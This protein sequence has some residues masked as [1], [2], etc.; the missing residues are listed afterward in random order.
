M[1]TRI[2]HKERA[3]RT[4]ETGLT[5]VTPLGPKNGAHWNQRL[6]KQTESVL[7][8][9]VLLLCF[10]QE[11]FK[12][13]GETKEFHFTTSPCK[14]VSKFQWPGFIHFCLFRFDW[15]Y[16][17]SQPFHLKPILSHRLSSPSSWAHGFCMISIWSHQLVSRFLDRLENLRILWI[18]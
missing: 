18:S 14:K 5:L 6:Q 1:V 9:Q 15:S 17:D 7:C 3:G 8:F 4:M 10:L 11:S 16:T 12:G 2:V 13:L